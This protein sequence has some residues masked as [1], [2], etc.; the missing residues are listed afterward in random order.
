M[1]QAAWKKDILPLM[2]E[3]VRTAIERVETQFPL[4]EIRLRLGCP[5]QLVYKDFDR[6]LYAPNGRGM[7]DEDE[8]QRLL[9]GICEQSV[10]AWTDEMKNGFVTLAGGYRVGLGGR[11]VQSDERTERFSEVNYFNFR[12][13]REVKNCS[14]SLLPM[15]KDERG[16]LLSTLIIS[17]PG[18]GKTTL[19]RDIIRAVS[20]G[21]GLKAQ[22]VSI[23][24]ERFEVAGCVRGRPQ[25]D[26]G[27]RSDIVSGTRKA[28]AMR[29]MLASLSPE[30]IATDEL[31]HKS[32]VEAALEAQSSGVTILSTAHGRDIIDVNKRPSMAQ[33]LR[34][35]VFNRYVE[36]KEIGSIHRVCN[37]DGEE[38]EECTRS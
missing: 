34:E 31:Q 4:N 38:V 13:V 37:E 32:D 9:L 12:I 25:F 27:P 14:A 20:S 15:I 19:L 16:K 21:Q 29:K 10:Y 1:D 23:A 7:L 11:M 2:P 35:R 3:R 17:P 26:I 36:L 5:I 33:L 22:K 30:V 8:C 6:L 28:L 18:L 24:D